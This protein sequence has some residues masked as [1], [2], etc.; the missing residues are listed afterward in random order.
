MSQTAFCWRSHKRTSA[1]TRW[2]EKWCA[3]LIILFNSTTLM[4]RCTEL[5]STPYHLSSPLYQTF[6]L[7]IP[8]KIFRGL[9]YYYL[10]LKKFSANWYTSHQKVTLMG[11]NALQNGRRH[12]KNQLLHCQQ[13]LIL[14][15]IMIIS[16]NKLH[17]V[18]NSVPNFGTGSE[19]SATH[20]GLCITKI[21]REP[22]IFRSPR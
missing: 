19:S 21:A 12:R 5:G 8:R 2:Y 13:A 7:R 15:K 1:P 22:K 14:S 9:Q 18:P 11:E 16:F 3:L 17:S 6:A 20:A 10:K 4:V